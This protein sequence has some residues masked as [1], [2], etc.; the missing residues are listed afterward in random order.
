VQFLGGLS[1]V[2][3][4]FEM[5]MKIEKILPLLMKSLEKDP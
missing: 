5:K 1:K 3:D 2:I 4:Q